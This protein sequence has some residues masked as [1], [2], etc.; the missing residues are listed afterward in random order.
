M[1]KKQM[2]ACITMEG[3]VQVLTE[4]PNQ[5]LLLA[6]PHGVGKTSVI[7]QAADRLNMAYLSLLLGQ[8]A[9]PGDLTGIPMIRSDRTHYAAPSWWPSDD[10]PVLVHLDELNR[11][12]PELMNAVM[13]LAL[14]GEIFGRKLPKG[15]ICVACVNHGDE[16][17][18][19]SIDPALLS[20]FNLF[21]LTP[22]VDEWLAWARGAG[23]DRRVTAYIEEHPTHLDPTTITDDLA[24]SQ[25]RRA[26]VRVGATHPTRALTGAAAL[27]AQG[28]VG[29]EMAQLYHEWVKKQITYN[30]V[31]QRG[32]VLGQPD[33][34]WVAWFEAECLSRGEQAARKVLELIDTDTMLPGVGQLLR[35]A[36]TAQLRVAQVDRTVNFD[37]ANINQ[38]ILCDCKLV[39]IK[40]PSL[41]SWIEKEPAKSVDATHLIF[42]DLP[43]TVNAFTMPKGSKGWGATLV[44]TPSGR[45]WV[46]IAH[47]R[48]QGINAFISGSH[49][50]PLAGA[51]LTG[52][53]RFTSTELDQIFG[54][55]KSLDLSQ[56]KS[57]A[58]RLILGRILD[59]RADLAASIGLTI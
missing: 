41:V 49:S 59:P 47:H 2:I 52:S 4:F 57:A 29:P 50:A 56:S 46:G 11:G 51:E 3:V 20:R 16:Y 23:V 9:D 34:G 30:K 10:R 1:A 54:R 40:A 37:P 32:L 7:K 39:T 38:S 55:D 44:V 14:E 33:Q 58:I 36:F 18:V 24:V 6:G 13:Q 25:N 21:T 19:N 5:N 12:R 48:M 28:A 43:G 8:L 17:S 15:S 45:Q 42:V 26:W 27:V 35:D 31:I 53:A 22:T